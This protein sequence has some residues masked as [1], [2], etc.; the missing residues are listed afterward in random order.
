[1]EFNKFVFDPPGGFSD[2]SFYEDT[3]ENAREILQRQH[4]QTRDYING[5]I[6]ALNS[7]KEGESGSEHIAS[8]KIDGVEGE[9]VFS[10]I[11]SIK[12]QLLDA[13]AG[14]IND[15]SV[16]SE[17]LSAGAVTG[18]K[19]A[20]GSVSDRHFSS[21]AEC[22]FA[23]EV[24]N[25][26]GVPASEYLP[27]RLTPDFGVFKER[28]S[29]CKMKCQYGKNKGKYR[30]FTDSDGKIKK[31]SFEDFSVS[32]VVDFGK[33]SGKTAVYDADEN[34]DL[35]ICHT[36]TDEPGYIGIAFYK[37]ENGETYAVK[38]I[39]LAPE[40]GGSYRLEDVLISEDDLYALYTVSMSYGYY[41]VYIYKFSLSGLEDLT[42]SVFVFSDTMN[43]RRINGRLFIAD[44]NMYFHNYRIKDMS[45]SSFE[46]FPWYFL[47]EESGQFLVY[48][49][50]YIMV[51]ENMLPSM[52][53]V[54]FNIFDT[55]LSGA[56]IRDKYIYMNLSDYLFR[57]RIL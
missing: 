44:G 15:G 38:R 30:Y 7:K 28:A 11:K 43:T 53:S 21:D 34:G 18:E 13:S 3:P 23:N 47:G 25:I 5:V 35:Y 51:D 10:Q 29:D 12:K 32:E 46:T 19:I 36:T 39:R 48:H 14:I 54:K 8:P 57:S 22:P 55:D 52:A 27:L 2:S 6:D 33:I 20:Y 49:D 41:M 40:S 4:N 1:M 45:F 31:L 42:E 16:T 50:N 37:T 26:N 56:F 9:D 24:K 17:K